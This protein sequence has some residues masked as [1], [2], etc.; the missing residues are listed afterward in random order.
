[1]FPP[2]TL[3]FCVLGGVTAEAVASRRAAGQRAHELSAC[4]A[5]TLDSPGTHMWTQVLEEVRV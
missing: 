5:A 2:P 1:M 4:A 3:V